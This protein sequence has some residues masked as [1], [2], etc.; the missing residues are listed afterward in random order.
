LT[1][2]IKLQEWTESAPL[3]LSEPS[4]RRLAALAPLLEMK[5]VGGRW[6]LKPRGIVG[7]IGLA[8]H[9][10]DLAPKYP[11]ANLC[12]MLATISGIPRLLESTALMGDLGLADLLVAAFVQ[13]TEALLAA[14]LRRDYLE[15]SEPLAVLRGRLDL[16]AHLRRPEALRTTLNCRHEQYTHNTPFN[17]V[18]RQTADVCHTLWPELAARLL[19][20]RHRLAALPRATLSPADIERF[21]YDRVTEGYRPV[22]ALCRL[23]LEGTSLDLDGERALGSSFVIRTWP[24]FEQFLSCSLRA[25]LGA[26]WRV[27]TQERTTLDRAQAI[28]IRP[29]VVVFS[30]DQAIAVLDAKYKLRSTG[31]PK[32]GDAVQVL[33]Y[34]RRYGVRRA[35]LVYPDKP[36]EAQIYTSHDRHNEIATYGLSLSSEWHHLEAALDQLAAHVRKTGLEPSSDTELVKT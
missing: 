25:R 19:R 33:A 22:H 20:L 6:T 28:Q 10:L 16:P 21:H 15:Y 31:A 2:V 17:A 23:I 34:A 27:E 18:L 1:V 29:D 12:R 24:L 5:P 7:R 30:G 26:P 9:T 13:R 14:G 4:V 36:V 35:W 8:E 11:V 3:A 32:P